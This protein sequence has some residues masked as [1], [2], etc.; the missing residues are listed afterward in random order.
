M[1]VAFFAGANNLKND[2]L[3]EIILF[4]H[5]FASI[6]HFANRE[7]GDERERSGVG[8]VEFI[9]QATLKA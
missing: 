1:L 8:K 5:V 3:E 2:K 6:M 9:R 7:G 4:F